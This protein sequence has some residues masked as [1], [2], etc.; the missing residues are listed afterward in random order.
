LV[1]LAEIGVTPAAFPFVIDN[2]A[3]TDRNMPYPYAAA[4]R[5]AASIGPRARLMVPY[6]IRALN[7][8][9]RDDYITFETIRG[10]RSSSGEYTTCQIEAIRALARI[11]SAA[12]EAVP[13]LEKL[14]KQPPMARTGSN[15][16]QRVPDIAAEAT[17]AIL[18]IRG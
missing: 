2:L 18:A 10:H 15:R 1:T 4:A 7:N 8:E 6:L 5:A 12:R 14:S 9:L 16:L 3:N 17:A 11:G 13:Y